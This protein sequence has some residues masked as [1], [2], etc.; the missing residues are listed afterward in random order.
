MVD[1]E[2]ARFRESVLER[3]P[4]IPSEAMQG[5]VFKGSEALA[6]KLIDAVVPSLDAAIAILNA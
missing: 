3:R 5:Q 6:N 2:G 1:A 4:G